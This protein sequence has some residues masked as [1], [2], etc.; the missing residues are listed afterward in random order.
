MSHDPLPSRV[1]RFPDGEPI[2]LGDQGGRRMKRRTKI[3]LF[4]FPIGGLIGGGV[5]TLLGH[6]W[7]VWLLTLMLCFAAGMV[8][9]RVVK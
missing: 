2:T 5:P 6:H 7:A 9:P 1:F 3:A 4:A 8:I